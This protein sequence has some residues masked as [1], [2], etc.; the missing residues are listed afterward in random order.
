MD[1]EKEI[2]NGNAAVGILIASVFISIAI[3]VQSG[4]AGRRLFFVGCKRDPIDPGHYIGCS[5]HYCNL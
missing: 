4:I 2:S 5:C 3:V 1:E